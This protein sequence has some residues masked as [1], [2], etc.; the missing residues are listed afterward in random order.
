MGGSGVRRGTAAT[1]HLAKGEQRLVDAGGL[2]QHLSRRFS[3]LQPLTSRQVHEA[4]LPKL[5]DAVVVFLGTGDHGIDVHSHDAVA[6][7]GLQVELMTAHLPV[8]HASADHL[9]A[10]MVLQV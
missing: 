6:A 1:T 5:G 7:R 4:D 9:W 2:L 8:L 3:I 10:T